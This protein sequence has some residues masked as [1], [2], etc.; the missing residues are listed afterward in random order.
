MCSPCILLA[1][2]LFRRRGAENDVDGQALGHGRVGIPVDAL[3][4]EEVSIRS[5]DSLHGLVVPTSGAGEANGGSH[6]SIQVELVGVVEGIGVGGVFAVLVGV[7]FQRT[8]IAGGGGEKSVCVNVVVTMP[9]IGAGA[10]IAQSS[11]PRTDE[12]VAGAG[13]EAKAQEDGQQD[14]KQFLQVCRCHSSKTLLSQML[15]LQPRVNWVADLRI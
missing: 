15:R 9:G 6:V 12:S 3:A 8:G 10:G 5:R 14:G 13:R 4:L 11:R 2:S 7:G 1:L